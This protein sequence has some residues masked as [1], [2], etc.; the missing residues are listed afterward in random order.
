MLLRDDIVREVI[1]H[2][3][4]TRPGETN[5]LYD[6]YTRYHS[7]ESGRQSTFIKVFNERLDDYRSR[8]RRSTSR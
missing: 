1:S 3:I 8:S 7:S 6:T 5:Q 4:V 2:V